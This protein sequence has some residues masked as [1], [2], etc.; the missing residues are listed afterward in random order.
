MQRQYKQKE[1]KKDVIYT[2]CIPETGKIIK[3]KFLCKNSKNRMIFQNAEQGNTLD[4]HPSRIS[5]LLNF[6]QVEPEQVLQG[7]AKQ[8]ERKSSF[9]YCAEELKNC[10]EEEKRILA[11]SIGSPVVELIREL[12][13]LASYGTNER[14]PSWWTNVNE[15]Y[16]RAKRILNEIRKPNAG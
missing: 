13:K 12:E 16:D 15:K 11:D 7:E 6:C 8:E 9:Y 1:P 2:I 10:S 5:Y 14:L 3:I 4:F